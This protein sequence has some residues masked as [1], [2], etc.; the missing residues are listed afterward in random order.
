ML[1]LK[2]RGCKSNPQNPHFRKEQN[3]FHA[4][5]SV[6]PHAG[7]VEANRSTDLTGLLGKFWA[8]VACFLRKCILHLRKSSRSCPLTVVGERGYR[9]G[10]VQTFSPTTDKVSGRRIMSLKP[11]CAMQRNLSQKQQIIDMNSAERPGTQ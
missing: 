10:T 11:A 5:V 8:T 1:S 6:I 9:G 4:L 3:G 2:A 7:E